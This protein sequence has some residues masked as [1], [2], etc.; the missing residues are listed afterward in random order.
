MNRKYAILALALLAS[1]A[2][3]QE[4]K[5]EANRTPAQ[6]AQTPDQKFEALVARF[7]AKQQEVSEAY[8]RAT[9]DEERAK[10]LQG[11]PGA[12]FV[13]E[14]RAL[15]AEARGTDAA[16]RAWIWVLR[17]GK[18]KGET[19]DV[20]LSEYLGSAALV[21]LTGELRYADHIF[22]AE[23]VEDALQRMAEGSPHRNV[24]ASA[25]LTLGAILVESD[26]DLK[27]A[28]GRELLERV[29][30]EYGD[31]AY[32]AGTYGK[33]AEGCL[34]ELDHLQIGMVAPDFETLDENGAQWK[35]SDYRGK[36]VIVD[37]WG[38][39]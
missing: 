4:K 23:R 37:F 18:D 13:P 17:L 29:V 11:L 2:Q 15:A 31:V 21:E 7:K 22:G 3:A 27:M 20:L 28:G 26:D 9:T 6:E 39:W 30:A 1:A 38:N 10:V 34:F 19:L 36:V 35:L 5:P 16:A 12:E 33:E 14:F 24:Q 8:A 25:L 32:R